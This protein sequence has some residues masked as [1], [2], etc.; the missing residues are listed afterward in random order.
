MSLLADELNFTDYDH[1]TSSGYCSIIIPNHTLW[2]K[3]LKH[4]RV[5]LLRRVSTHRI[6]WKLIIKWLS[7]LLGLSLTIEESIDVCLCTFFNME[8]SGK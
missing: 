3:N 7:I 4:T 1:Q 6:F 2:K 8:A 5:D